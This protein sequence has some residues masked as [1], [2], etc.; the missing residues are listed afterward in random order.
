MTNPY[1]HGCYLMVIKAGKKEKQIYGH[2]SCN[3]NEVLFIK[4]V[5]VKTDCCGS[6]FFLFNEI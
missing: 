4:L 2:T 5:S 3:I 6:H 1:A